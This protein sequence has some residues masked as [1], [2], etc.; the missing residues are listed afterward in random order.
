M[1]TGALQKR[2]QA[3][4]PR[5]RGSRRA[6][7]WIGTAPNPYFAPGHPAVV[8]GTSV[9]FPFRTY[10]LSTRSASRWSPGGQGH[11]QSP[12]V[13]LPRIWAD[14]TPPD[15]FDIVK[16]DGK[17]VLTGDGEP[18]SWGG[19]SMSAYAYDKNDRGSL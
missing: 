17:P 16:R 18:Y 4:D 19:H 5:V 2:R 14:I 1:V 12:R 13:A 9:R 6:L 3:M 8:D 11:E 10:A 15:A 7:A